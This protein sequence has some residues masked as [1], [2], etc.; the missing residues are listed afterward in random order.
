M[1]RINIVKSCPKNHC[2]MKLCPC[3]FSPLCDLS[4]LSSFLLR[5]NDYHESHSLQGP[6][7]GSIFSLCYGTFS[8]ASQRFWSSI[9]TCQIT[10][11]RQLPKLCREWSGT[12]FSSVC[13]ICKIRR[14]LSSPVPCSWWQ[15]L[16]LFLGGDILAYL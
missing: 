3:C 9:L 1:S 15:Q 4:F 11:Y 8:G 13:D 10:L 14:G 16:V 6:C 12:V 5:F 7:P 2:F